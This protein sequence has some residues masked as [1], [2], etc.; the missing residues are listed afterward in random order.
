[1][2]ITFTK[3]ASKDV[4]KLPVADVKAIIAKLETFAESGEGDV[5]K[6][7]GRA[8]Y[9]LRHGN[10]RALFT[11]DGKVVVIRVAHRKHVY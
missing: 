2:Q 1:M 9:R 3:S 10:Y 6:L 4:K 5:K 8:G 7:K 11:K